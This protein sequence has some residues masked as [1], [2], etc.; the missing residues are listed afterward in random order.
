VRRP[1]RIELQAWLARLCSDT[2]GSSSSNHLCAAEAILHTGVS[3]CMMCVRICVCGD[4]Y[5]LLL[6]KQAQLNFGWCSLWIWTKKGPWGHLAT[7]S[8]PLPLWHWRW[9][10]L[11]CCCWR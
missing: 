9:L 8:T 3:K 7:G 11:F 4:A 1:Q 6:R 2:A 10:T 5:T